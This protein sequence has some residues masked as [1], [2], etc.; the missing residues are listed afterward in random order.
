MR[1]GEGGADFFFFFSF[2]LLITINLSSFNQYFK[3]YKI[4]MSSLILGDK[5]LSL[6]LSFYRCKQFNLRKTSSTWFF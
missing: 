1:N 5:Y 2:L 3:S 6:Y 4:Y